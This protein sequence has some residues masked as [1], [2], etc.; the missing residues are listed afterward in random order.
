MITFRD[1]LEESLRKP[2]EI[3]QFR[4]A[5]SNIKSVDNR[6][7]QWRGSA[8]EF[9]GRYGF[10]PLGSGKYGAVFANRS[11]PFVIKV[12]MKDTAYLLWLNFCKMHPNNPYCPKIRGKVVR[13]GDNFMAVRL[14]KLEDG[15]NPDQIYNMAQRGDK[16]AIQVVEFL[17]KYQKLLD[18]HS[19]NVMM[20]GDQLVITDPFY[21]FY[22]DGKFTMDPDDLV[23]FENIV[24]NRH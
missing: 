11:Y 4:Q 18:M 24:F 12:F 3:N 14:E 8:V 22:K 17:N 1:K 7:N 23:A 15:G 6:E 16:N 2:A 10:K 19:G 9:L 13:L 20:R 21:N 5:I